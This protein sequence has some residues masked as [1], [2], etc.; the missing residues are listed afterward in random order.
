V[1]RIGV[2]DGV[3]IV[4]R[5]GQPDAPLT[6]VTPG[7]FVG[8]IQAL[9]SRLQIGVRF[10]HVAGGRAPAFTVSTVPLQNFV[11]DVTFDRR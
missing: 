11:G 7:L 8:E 9:D 5:I 1:W 2:R 10:Q 3:A 4:Q 6:P